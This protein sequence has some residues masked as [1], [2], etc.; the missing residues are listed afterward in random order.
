MEARRG[1]VTR[2]RETTKCDAC[3]AARGEHCV[4][5]TGRRGVV[6]TKLPQC[7]AVRRYAY[8][9]LYGGG[10]RSA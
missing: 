4:N 2:I 8:L 10:R 5:Y 3:G 6:G 1:R 7:H 9:A